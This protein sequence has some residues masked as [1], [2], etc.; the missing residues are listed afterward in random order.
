MIVD[1]D[2]Y[3]TLLRDNVELVT[4]PIDHVES[5]AIVT[6]DGWRREV[7]VIVA[8]AGFDVTKYL[9]PIRAVGRRGVGLEEKWEQDG[10]GPRAFWSV[11]VPGFPNLFIMYGPNSQGGAGGGLSSMLQLWT[12][13]I[14]G[15]IVRTLERGAKEIEVKDDV[16][17][18]HN[19]ALDARTSQMIWMDPDSRDRNYYVSH[20]RVQ[21]MNAW[22]PAEHWEAMT[23]P[24]LERDFDV[25]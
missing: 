16:F 15:L 25:T 7:D 11:T 2:W 5:D 10:V 23:N 24:D 9:F 13:H 1:N 17:E 21:S 8:A 20:G 3:K 12:T 14:A 18:Q 19:A 4:D 6:A 22:A